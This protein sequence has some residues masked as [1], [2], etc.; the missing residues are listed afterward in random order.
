[1][2][3]VG[4]EFKV[5]LFVIVA[6]GLLAIMVLKAGDFYVKPGYTARFVFHH[7]SGIDRGSPVKLAGVRVGEVKEVHVVRN[8]SGETQ[9]EIDAWIAQGVQIEEDARMR[10]NAAGLLGEKYIEILPGT[11]NGKIMVDRGTLYGKSP[12]A[13]DDVAESATRFMKKAET[14]V[15]NVN[16]MIG[17]PNFKTS[18]RSTFTNS[19]KLTKNMLE[20][21]EDLKETI[22]SMKVVFGRL[23]DGEGTIGR[24]LRDEKM[25]KDLEAFVADI[26][27]HPWKL[28]KRD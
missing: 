17:D 10:I 1:M 12:M 24:L 4:L 28:L 26:K 2:K 22:A 6:L 15:E 3:K 25:A 27:A 9:V 5:G 16:E 21:S 13:I 19:D 20:V 8:A 18:V 14:A 23:K 11:P 7:I